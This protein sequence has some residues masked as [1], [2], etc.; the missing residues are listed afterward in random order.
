MIVF[1]AG[2]ESTG[3]TEL[4]QGLATHYNAQWVPEYSREYLSKLSRAYTFEDVET[5]ARKQIEQIKLSSG[6]D[7]TFVDT[8]LINTKVWFEKKFGRVPNWFLDC[9]QNYSRGRY[10]LCSPDLP[11]VHDPLRENPDIRKELDTIYESEIRK[12]AFPIFRIF[13]FG[14]SR[15]HNAISQINKWLKE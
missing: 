10:L 9:Y 5:I 15:F 8:D 1:I 12:N 14:E 7:L 11:W 3:K 13:G 4:A 2:S 6:N